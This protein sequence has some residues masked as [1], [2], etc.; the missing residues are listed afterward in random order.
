MDKFLKFGRFQR[1]HVKIQGEHAPSCRR[2]CRVKLPH[3]NHSQRRLCA[4]SFNTEPQAGKLGIP[5]FVV[6]GLTDR[7]SNPGLPLK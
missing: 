2:P 7:E 6:F 5:I 4:I 1:E 3:V